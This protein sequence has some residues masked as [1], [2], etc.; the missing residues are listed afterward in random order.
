MKKKIIFIVGPTAVGKTK[1]STDIANKFNGEIISCDSMQIYKGFNI[2]TAK[3]TKEEMNGINHHLIDIIDGDQSFNVSEYKQL[4]ENCI[5]K[6]YNKNS[7]P[8]FVGGTGLYVDSIFYDLKFTEAKDTSKLRQEIEKFYEDNGKEALYKWL[9]TLDYNLKDTIHKNNVKRV[10][11]A[12]EVCISTNNR[13]SMQKNDYFKENNKY[14]PLIIGLNIDRSILYDRINKRVDIM[15][16]EGLLDEVKYLY[17]LYGE[18]SQPFTAIGYKEFVPY[19]KNEISIENC[20][21]NI[22]QNSRKYAKRQLTWFKKNKN[23]NW[24]DTNTNYENLLENT[25]NIISNFLMEI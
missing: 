4:A 11:R 2:G 8:I 14:S 23:I 17:K 24:I 22:K 3:I 21:E 20:I 5:D 12:I 6:I 15:L 25:C 13:F 1:L 19:F 9:L 7:L 18:N 10:I 16:K